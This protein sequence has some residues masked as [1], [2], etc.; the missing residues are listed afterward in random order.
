MRKGLFVSTIVLVVLATASLAN[1]AVYTY[2]SSISDWFTT[3]NFTRASCTEAGL[4][5]IV[6]D[7]SVS[8]KIQA[9]Y[10]NPWAGASQVFMG[11]WGG[12]TW[13]APEG[14]RVVKVVMS[15]WYRSD[16]GQIG[17]GLFG[18]STG[19]E[20]T[21][22]LETKA[23][24]NPFRGWSNTV[25][26][27]ASA[28]NVSNLELRS[29]WM[30]SNALDMVVG[31]NN[32]PSYKGEITSVEITTEAIP[33]NPVPEPSALVMLAGGAAALAGTVIRKRG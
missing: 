10:M 19:Y 16:Y 31:I 25:V 27:I 18:G 7:S 6:A 8:N 26:D 2:D 28:D 32:D 20:D 29:W 21:K 17:Y 24:G 5:Y 4:P 1:A 13:Q 12:A 11:S 3:G 15:G 14:E 33:E 30:Q 9:M 23:D 22:Y